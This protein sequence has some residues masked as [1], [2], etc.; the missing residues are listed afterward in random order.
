[1]NI[2]NKVALRGLKKNR[3]QTIVT[4]IGVV[5]AAAMIMAVTT[6]TISLQ[7]YMVN[8][9]I[10]KYGNWHVGF[11][12]VDFS[13]G[14]E[15]ALDDRV[16]HTASF[17]NIGYAV[18]EGGENPDKPYLFIA[19]FN[20]KTFDTL[21]VDL[22]SGRLPMN[23]GE[24]LIPA[25]AMSNGGAEI[26]VGD[27]LVL[28]VGDRRNGD[29]SLNQHDPYDS[30]ETFVPIE[31]KTYTVVGIY[32]RPVFEEYTAPGYTAITVA[33]GADTNGSFSTFVSL[34]NPYQIHSYAE[35][36]SESGAYV[37][38]DKVLR[39]MGLSDNQIFN[40]FLYTVGGIL[41]ALVVIGAVFLIYNSFTISLNERTR[42]IGILRSVGATERQLRNSVLFEG[43]CIGVIGIPIGILIGIPAIGLVL[44]LTSRNFQNIMYD[45][46]PL[47]LHIS[48]PALAAAVV[49]SMITILISAYIP[50]RKAARTPVM[51]CIR[52]TNEIRMEAKTVKTSKAAGHIYGLEGNL[53]LKNF[54]RNRKRYRSIILSLTL[55]VV[56]FVSASVFGVYLKESVEGS[57]VDLDYDITFYSKNMDEKE[58]DEISGQLKK[59]YG[60]YES[61]SEVA[62]MDGQDMTMLTFRSENPS[63]SVTEMRDILRKN[64]ITS[65]YTLQNVSQMLE[66][67]RNI[68]F[69]VNLFSM[70]FIVMMTLV[71]V[72]NVFNTISTNI[73]LRRRELAMLRS[74][75][76]SDRSFDKMMRFECVLYG[77]RTLLF[78]FPIAAGVSWLIYMG[79]TS[80]KAGID[81]IFPWSSMAISIL[82]VFL[83][84][85]A[86]MLH[87]V[88]KIKKENIID[89]LRDEMT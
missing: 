67:N 10:K 6:L 3:T 15:Q 23:S 76:M 49:I 36:M 31:G 56:L 4:I 58:L 27:R 68:L 1:M 78:G 29:R 12:D 46:V 48:V 22:V 57:T 71:A 83:V 88:R 25:H 59:A 44:S 16:D 2:F 34:E 35:S 42:Q 32:Q 79:F 39:F 26:S 19:G 63:Q 69:I 85:F 72:T 84:I 5:L 52:Q 7:N 18:I 28:E 61:S 74:V 66:D 70:V 45:G 77:L 38:N 40:V 64:G 11:E 41:I 53:A 37:L 87:V 14:Q 73:R 13:F 80:G 21:T 75:G 65:G 54:K 8:G 86:T 51:E 50:A 9:S 24:I 17:Q 89:A 33:T 55:S 60:V 81:F 47:S 30:G 20:D 62:V 43:I 82:G